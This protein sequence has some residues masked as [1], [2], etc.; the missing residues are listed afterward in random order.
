MRNDQLVVDEIQYNKKTSADSGDRF[1]IIRSLLMGPVGIVFWAIVFG[2]AI[3]YAH[4]NV[5]R[6]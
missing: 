1:G 4:N 5:F 6:M 3:I 2:Y